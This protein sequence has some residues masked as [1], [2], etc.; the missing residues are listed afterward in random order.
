MFTND[1]GNF[2]NCQSIIMALITDHKVITFNINDTSGEHKD[3]ENN[4]TL[5]ILKYILNSF[6]FYHTTVIIFLQIKSNTKKN[7]RKQLTKHYITI[8]LFLILKQE[9]TKSTDT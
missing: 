3:F 8:L 9:I 2:T 7:L 1:A 6:F 5:E 4:N